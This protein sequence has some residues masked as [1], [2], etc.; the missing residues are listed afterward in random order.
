MRV[1]SGKR[2][3]PTLFVG[4]LIP[5]PPPPRNVRDGVNGRDFREI[6][7]H[8][9]DTNRPTAIAASASV[10]RA[11]SDTANTIYERLRVSQALPAFSLSLSRNYTF[12]LVL[13]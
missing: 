6:V 2:V 7:V 4:S 12:P 10:Y 13:F 9:V 5:L 3:L 1:G 8:D 11:S